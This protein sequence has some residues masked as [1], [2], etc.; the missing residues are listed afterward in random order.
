MTLCLV[1][2]LDKPR[3]LKQKKVI[4]GVR[5]GPRTLKQKE[6]IAG[7]RAGPRTLKQEEVIAGVRFAEGTWVWDRE[8]DGGVREI[9]LIL[10]R[11]HRFFGET[12][13]QGT[14]LWLRRAITGE[15][16]C[17]YPWSA[18]LMDAHEIA[19]HTFSAYVVLNFETPC[20]KEF[21][22]VSLFV[23]ENPV[24]FAGMP[25]QGGSHV[26]FG[27]GGRILKLTL[28]KEHIIDGVPCRGTIEFG[29]DGKVVR[30]E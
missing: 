22:L 10:K 21:R 7:V 8:M 18:E 25:I 15:D 16:P 30:P 17:H 28:D 24:E 11:D 26:I 29:E 13:N 4:A 14:R 27:P 12:F 20:L 5:V 9:G 1:G 2:C 19:G 3:T 6:V 23:P